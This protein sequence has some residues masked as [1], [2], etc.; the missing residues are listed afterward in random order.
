MNNLFIA[1]VYHINPSLGRRMPPE[2]RID[3][4]LSQEADAF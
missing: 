1:S 3:V 4:E 2:G